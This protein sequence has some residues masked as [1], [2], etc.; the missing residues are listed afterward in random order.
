MDSDA[1]NRTKQMGAC[2][3]IEGATQDI[4]GDRLG[5]STGVTLLASHIMDQ[6]Q[7]EVQANTTSAK[8]GHDRLLP[9]RTMKNNRPRADARLKAKQVADDGAILPERN[10]VRVEIDDH[11]HRIASCEL[12]FV[13]SV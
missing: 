9:T 2:L 12:V 7:M 11:C 5:L 1:G 13:A 8:A 10:R 4:M 6:G 3:L